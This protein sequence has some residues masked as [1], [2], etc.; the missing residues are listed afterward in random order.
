MLKRLLQ[1]L[2]LSSPGPERFARAGAAHSDPGLHRAR[3]RPAQ[4][5]Q[6][7]VRENG[8]GRRDPLGARLDR[9][10]HRQAARREK[11]S[12]G[13]CRV[14]PR[15]HQPAGARAGRHADAVRAQRRRGAQPALRRHRRSRRCGS[16]WTCGARPSASTRW[17]RRSATC[18]SRNPGRTCSSRSTRARSPCRI[19][20]RA[21]PA[22]STSPPG[23]SSSARPKAG[24]T[25]TRCTRTSRSTC[26]RAPSPAARPAPASS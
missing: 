22:S 15:R 12:A 26:T 25:W 14:R 8:Q 7:H 17:K 6:G 2:A 21:A 11:Q 13:R 24:S 20:P 18:R 4:V 3:D 16:A 23:C 1:L 9:R 5:L 19:R 10:D